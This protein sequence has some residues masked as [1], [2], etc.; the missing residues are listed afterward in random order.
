[1]K[2]ALILAAQGADGGR[3]LLR[4]LA[5]AGMQAGTH[6]K[7]TVV[8]T[9]DAPESVFAA[10]PGVKVLHRSG[11]IVDAWR[12]GAEAS[13]AERLSLLCEGDALFDA[14]SLWRLENALNTSPQA[15]LTA[16]AVRC[17]DALGAEQAC[18]GAWALPQGTLARRDVLMTALARTEDEAALAAQLF[19]AAEQSV[20]ITDCV[21]EC[22]LA[23]GWFDALCAAPRGLSGARAAEWAE[24]QL[25]ALY[26]AYVRAGLNGPEAMQAARAEC[27]A[28][29]KAAWLPLESDMAPDALFASYGAAM[30]AA[31]RI[32]PDAAGGYEPYPMFADILR[33]ECD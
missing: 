23:E 26:L 16:G 21:C 20:E 30:D 32:D 9:G 12:A 5:S 2:T 10:F 1:M 6:A 27:A 11:S 28:F 19:A 18:V 8:L 14:Y 25:A 31:M 33:M 3:A 17:F 22:R 7:A 4:T 13:D 24:K 15:A 29:F